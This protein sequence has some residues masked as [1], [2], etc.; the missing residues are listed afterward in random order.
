[1]TSI[2]P[3]LQTLAL[4]LAGCAF[5]LPATAADWAPNR[6]VEFVVS[7]GPGGGTDQFAR[8]VQ[9][10]VQKYKL[11]PVPVVV[12]NK[13]GGA[14]TEAFVYAKS[15]KGDANKVVFSTNLSYL[16]PLITKV[17]YTIDDVTP[18]A[19]MAADEFVL[20]THTDAPYKNAADLIADARAKNGRFK[21]AGAQSKDT[22]H[23]LTRK[24]EKATGVKMTYVPFKSGG[25]VAVQL[26]GAHVDANTNNPS[27]SASHWR[28]GK[29]RP[30]CVFSAKRLDSKEKV[31][32]EQGFGDLPTCK[33]AGIPVDEFHMP[34]TVWLA[35]DVKPEQVKYYENLLDQVR[36]K[37]EWKAWLARG[38]QS[39]MFLV[40]AKLKDYVAADIKVHR[41]QF[42]Q[43]GWL[44]KN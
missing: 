9:T 43:D 36:Q 42:D 21:M 6:P 24:I 14:G 32:A 22:D 44:V 11:L 30:L 10:I 28:A 25:E 33:E 5:A 34:R 1:M 41:E 37:P 27:E 8:V 38:T 18:L 29:V 2:Q 12:S 19:V 13:S 7:A 39:D 4:A 20:W 17:G 31:T 35:D 3:S 15:Q 23:I 16:M 26:S 40:G